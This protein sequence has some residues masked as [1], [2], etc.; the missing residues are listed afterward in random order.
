MPKQTF[1]NLTEDKKSRI[2]DA[3]IAELGSK[4]FEKV[5]VAEIIEK[6]D[7]PR[8]SFYQ[9]FEDL[10]DLY[11]YVLQVTGEEKMCY[12]QHVMGQM[13]DWDV[14]K[15]IRELYLAGLKFAAENPRLAAVGNYYFRED[16]SLK[17]EIFPDMEDRG[18]EFFE[19]ILVKGRERGEIDPDVDI[20][21]ASFIL[22]NLTYDITDYFF[23]KTGVSDGLLSHQEDYLK[24]ADKMLYIIEVGL[25]NR[26]K[27]PS[28]D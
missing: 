6:A 22:Y 10:K 8:G 11:R 23:G 24:L 18:R 9:Y 14:F 13:A 7:I 2:L 19:A 4:P 12:M 5:S 17:L 20:P 15:I 21:M 1:F 16:L 26:K 25:R 3:A 28:R 27:E